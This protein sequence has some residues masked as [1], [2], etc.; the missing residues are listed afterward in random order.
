MTNNM[1]IIPKEKYLLDFDKLVMY[2]NTK[3]I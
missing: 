1:T 2:N 3:N